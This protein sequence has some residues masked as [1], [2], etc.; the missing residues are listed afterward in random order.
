MIP[1]LSS[2]AEQG[3]AAMLTPH[4]TSLTP[5]ALSALPIVIFGQSD[6]E[7]AR[8][9]IRVVGQ[10]D[11]TVVV[12]D[13]DRPVGRVTIEVA[14]P[15]NL[16]LFDNSAAGGHFHANLRILGEDSAMLFHGLGDGYVALHDVFL[17]SRGQVLLWGRGA[18]AV[19]LSIEHEGA[20]RT[21]LVGE[22]ALISSGI[23]I[24]NHDMHAVHDLKSGQRINRPPVDTVIERHVWVGQNALLLGCQLIGRGAI[25][26]AASLVKGV[27]EPRTAVGGAPARVIRTHVSWGRDIEGMTEAELRAVE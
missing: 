8:L 6:P 1:G 26:G 20:G 15:G 5:Q 3:L 21:L 11:L 10:A 17:R 2:I 24:R 22:D 4:A 25:I 7:L 14:R 18:T 12:T 9:G 23:W 27:V 13:P 19:G 16:V